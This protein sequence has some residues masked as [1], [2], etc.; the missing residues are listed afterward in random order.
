M[1]LFSLFSVENL[2]LSNRI[3]MILCNLLPTIQYLQVVIHHDLQYLPQ[4]MKCYFYKILQLFL[5]IHYLSFS[6]ARL[7]FC[8]R[9][10]PIVDKNMLD[11]GCITPNA[12]HNRRQ[13]AERSVA[14]WRP[15]LWHCYVFDSWP[16][17]KRVKF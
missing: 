16:I 10:T 12:S 9:S 17:F 14:F 2:E 6:I 13:K 3:K 4:V 1:L 7:L 8:F 15:S 5:H 11:A